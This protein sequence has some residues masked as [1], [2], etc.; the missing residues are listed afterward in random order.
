VQETV[1]TS[2]GPVTVATITVKAA[3]DAQLRQKTGDAFNDAFT[4]EALRAGGDS[5][6]EATIE[7]LGF[8]TDYPDVHHAAMRVN[9]LRVSAKGEEQPAGP[10]GSILTGSTAPSDAGS[11][12]G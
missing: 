6:P 9:G 7:K 10:A 5:E 12:T 3:K 11:V 4:V 1:A 8:L 2:L